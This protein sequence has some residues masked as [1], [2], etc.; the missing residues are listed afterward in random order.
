M[1]SKAISELRAYPVTAA[2]KATWVVLCALLLQWSGAEF[3]PLWAAT[4]DAVAG[5]HASYEPGLAERAA[6]N[7]ATR[8][9]AKEPRHS[10]ALDSVDPP[11]LAVADAVPL[12][13]AAPAAVRCGARC[14][15]ASPP[16]SHR[17]RAPPVLS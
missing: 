1:D 6:P 10:A 8:V 17:P 4:S 2:F 7:K 11:L 16:S 13:R 9:A 14:A 15:G 12:F 3:R 5:A